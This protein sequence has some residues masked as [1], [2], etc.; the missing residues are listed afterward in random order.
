M[1]RSVRTAGVLASICCDRGAAGA[2]ALRP[3]FCVKATGFA[4][5]LLRMRVE[6]WITLTEGER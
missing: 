4:G 1:R 2:N 5:A 3:P 6:R